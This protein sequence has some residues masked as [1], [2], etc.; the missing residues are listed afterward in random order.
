MRGGVERVA[1]TAQNWQNQSVPAMHCAG[2][3]SLYKTTELFA[4]PSR[5]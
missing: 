2:T 5:S 1:Q 3:L 4:D